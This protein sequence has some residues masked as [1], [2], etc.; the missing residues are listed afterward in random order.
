MNPSVGTLITSPRA[1][2][3]SDPDAEVEVRVNGQEMA[4]TS[5]DGAVYRVRA[6]KGNKLE[7]SSSTFH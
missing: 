6:R 5:D 2:Q 7:V 3:L 1:V 4:I